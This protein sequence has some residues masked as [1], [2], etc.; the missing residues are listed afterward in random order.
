MPARAAS[1]SASWTSA[2]SNRPARLGAGQAERA[3]EPAACL[4]RGDDDRAQAEPPHESEMLGVGD[5]GDEHVVGDLAHVGRLARARDP[6]RSA[7]RVGVGREA[8]AELAAELALGVVDVR[9]GDLLQQPG[10]VEDAHRAPVGDLG[11]GDLHDRAQRLLVVQR[12]VEDP[13]GA[14]EEVRAPACVALGLQQRPALGDVDHDDDHAAD[15]AIG[16]RHRGEGRVAVAQLAGGRWHLPGQLAVERRLPGGE[17][18]PAAGDDGL[19][20]RGRPRPAARRP[21]ARRDRR[22]GGR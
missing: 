5:P 4:Q 1:S 9:G 21:S 10:V 8:A 3:E 12:R 16:L 22:P 20:P 14:R 6:V 15:R 13:S 11:D 18:V 2:C 17:D 7:R 19:A